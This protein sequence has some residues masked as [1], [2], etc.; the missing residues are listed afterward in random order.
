MYGRLERFHYKHRDDPENNAVLL[1][2]MERIHLISK[3][4]AILYLSAGIGFLVYVV[5]MYYFFNERVLMIASR[6][7]WIDADLIVGYLITTGIHTCMI[8]IAVT[9]VA[10]ADSAILLFVASLA[11]Y[12]DVFTNDLAELNNE[13]TSM[14]PDMR[15]I[16]RKVRNLCIQHQDII[17]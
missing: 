6:F 9:G 4:L 10:A 5:Y 3:A 7:P 11:G 1:R 16:R 17:E 12:A 14:C 8:I 15:F 2:L 13:L